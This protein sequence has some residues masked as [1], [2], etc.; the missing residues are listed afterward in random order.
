MKKILKKWQNKFGL[1]DWT[2][3]LIKAKQSDLKTN[4]GCSVNADNLYNEKMKVAFIRYVVFEERSIIHE[5]LHI[6]YPE[7]SETKIEKRTIS[8]FKELKQFFLHKKQKKV[9]ELRQKRLTFKQIGK[10]LGISMES[11]RQLYAS[12]YLKL[13]EKL[14]E[15][16]T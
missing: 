4:W 11:A 3:Y 8:I 9:Y 7:D 13:L 5:L 15:K 16:R 2:I 6:A 12:Y 10:K 14:A 1:T